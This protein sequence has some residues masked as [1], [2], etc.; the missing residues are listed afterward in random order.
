[1]LLNKQRSNFL[2]AIA[3]TQATFFLQAMD[4]HTEQPTAQQ[5]FA[6]LQHRCILPLAQSLRTEQQH[7]AAQAILPANLQEIVI[8][9]S[10]CLNNPNATQKSC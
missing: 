3:L 10:I 8:P 1:M 9:L 7:I 4:E 2:L 5:P 6:T